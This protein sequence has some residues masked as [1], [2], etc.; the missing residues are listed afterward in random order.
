LGLSQFKL[1]LD[2]SL[3]ATPGFVA[4]SNRFA[5]LQEVS[6]STKRS[7][8]GDG[9]GGPSGRAVRLSDD[10]RDAMGFAGEWL[11]FQWLERHHDSDFTPAG[12]VSAYR[13]TVFP[14]EGDDG[15]GWDFQVPTRQGELRYE[16]KTTVSDGGQIE[17]GET[18]VLA[19]QEHSRNDWWRLIVVTNVLNANRRLRILPNPFGPRARGRYVFVGQGLRLRY[20]FD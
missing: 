1:A 17:L 6:G 16:V 18:Q 19:A 10:Q 15:L 2:T 7:G 5:Q 14:G 13:R 20:V 4:T 11:A 9:G 12:W 8:G 3:E